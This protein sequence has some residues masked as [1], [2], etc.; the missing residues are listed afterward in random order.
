M[1]NDSMLPEKP[2]SNLVAEATVVRRQEAKPTK[3]RTTVDWRQNLAARPLL[4]PGDRS[5]S[6]LLLSPS[7]LYVSPHDRLGTQY[8]VHHSTIA[9]HSHSTVVRP[10][11]PRT[12]DVHVYYVHIECCGPTNQR[13][14]VV[15]QNEH[16][17]V[18]PEP[19]CWLQVIEP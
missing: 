16:N 12:R 10:R 3:E 8:T 7:L 5:G 6:P 9:Y 19:H 14:R 11:K 17:N 13:S 18:G 2:K 15:N 1:L 4:K